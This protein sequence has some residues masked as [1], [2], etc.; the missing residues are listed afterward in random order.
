MPESESSFEN[1]PGISVVI[2]C[3]NRAHYLRA[4]L[5][6]VLDQ[7]HS[8][9]E[10]IVVD[11]GST[12]GTIEIL[13]SYGDK[14]SWISEPDDGHAAAINKGWRMGNEGIL[15]WLNADDVWVTPDGAAMAAQLLASNPDIDVVYGNCG[16]INDDGEIVG[17]SY[18]REWNLEHAVEYCD[19]C[20]PQ[21]AAFIRRS[22]IEKVGWLDESIESGKDHDLWLRIGLKGALKHFP[23]TLAYERAT[24][25]TWSSRG[26]ITAAGKIHLTK[27][28]FAHSEVPRQ[29]EKKRRR[30][31][32]NAYLKA[33]EYA[34]QGG[35][36]WVVWLKCITFA[37]LWDPSNLGRIW[38]AWRGPI[39]TRWVEIRD[40]RTAHIK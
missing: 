1:E 12:D 28:F 3:F 31:M 38:K 19:H 17:A 39:A 21:P 15:A 6:S 37:L 40:R 2:P 23:V 35:R 16:A 13:E 26:D 18:V 33:G 9:I 20:I 32:S 10:C 8:R 24:E 22:I 5:D 29:I 11:G 27:K 30:A 25:G 14:I 34:L 7:N 36:Y 4:T